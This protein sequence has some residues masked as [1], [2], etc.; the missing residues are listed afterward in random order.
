MQT[1]RPEKV[2]GSVC[3]TSCREIRDETVSVGFSFQSH[4]SLFKETHI[5]NTVVN[6]PTESSI[7]HLINYFRI[8]W[9]YATLH[10]Y[11]TSDRDRAVITKANRRRS[12][13]GSQQAKNSNCQRKATG[14]LV[15]VRTVDARE[16][17]RAV[18]Q[19]WAHQQK[20]SQTVRGN[21]GAV[22]LF[23]GRVQKTAVEISL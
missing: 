23:V 10:P 19:T 8:T 4:L 16:R 18:N 2:I 3:R 21:D 1:T 20:G 14:G 15:S 6:G 9:F 12:S 5:R 11:T 7:N 22:E 13:A 17:V